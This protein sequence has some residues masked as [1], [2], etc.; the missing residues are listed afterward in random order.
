MT[1]EETLLAKLAE[2]H[3]PAGRQTLTVSDQ[4]AGWTVL[5]TANRRETLGSLVWEAAIHRTPPAGETMRSWADRIA[6]RVTAL[7][8]PLELIEIDAERNEGLVRSAGP[9]KRGE[10]LFYYEVLLRG[11][12]QAVVRR[13]QASHTPGSKREQVAFAVTHEALARLASDL[14]ASK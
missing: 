11:T 1:L 10:D 7:M 9:S 14:A 8:E 5:V 4:E 6:D 12:T 13:Y 2:W 3:P